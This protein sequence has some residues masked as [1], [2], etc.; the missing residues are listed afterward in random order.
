MPLADQSVDVVL[1]NCVINLSSHKRRTFREALRVLKPGGRLVVSDVVTP[2]EPDPAIKNDDTLRGE[3][4]AG[5]LTEKNLFALLMETG[6]GTAR[7]LKRFPYRVVSEHPFFSLTF[8][9]VKPS[10]AGQ[11]RAMYRGPLAAALTRSGIVL[12]VGES[13]LVSRDELPLE[14]HDFLVID[15]AGRAA[16]VSPEAWSCCSCATEPASAGAAISLCGQPTPAQPSPTPPLAAAPSRHGSGCLVCG[17]AVIYQESN[18]PAQC[19]YC[20][21]KLPANARCEQG[22]FVCDACHTTDAVAA[23]RHICKTTSTTDLITLLDEIRRHPAIFRHGPEHHVLVP[24]I[25]LTAYRNLGGKV[26]PEMFETAIARGHA[27]PGGACGFMGVCGAAVGVGIAFSLILGATPLTSEPRR[28][29]LSAVQ[30]VLGEITA[31]GAAARCCQRECWLA[32]RQAAALSRELL[33][34]PLKAAASLICRQGS[35][36][37]DCLQASCPLWPGPGRQVPVPLH[38]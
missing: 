2:V 14:P 28:Q 6:F 34:V 10:R 31:L 20:L 27:V 8:E 36:R 25:I 7:I 12:P 1:S 17:S 4:I 30:A 37:D 38:D 29:V 5:A 32:L 3:C 35:R 26:T 33:P 15:E 19:H 9:A 24:A 23:I 13:R 22:H 16:H 18:R 11:I 21:T